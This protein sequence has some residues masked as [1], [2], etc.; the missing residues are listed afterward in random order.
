MKINRKI[1][2]RLSV[3]VAGVAVMSSCSADKDSAGL[4]YMP[5][6]YRSAAIE[7]YVDYGEIR[8]VT[9]DD[10]KV[11]LS[12]MVPPSGTIPFYGTDSMTVALNLPYHRLA[13][14]SFKLS[15]GMYDAELTDVNEYEAAAADGNM[16]KL[17]EENVEGIFAKG[18]ELYNV[19][20]AHCHGDKGDG[21]GP[22]V[23]S[24]AYVGAAVLTSLEI[25]DGQMF[26]SI[27]YGKG[28]M[29][30]H[31]S[32]L[33]KEEIWTVI[34]YINKLKDGSYGPGSE[35]MTEEV[36]ETSEENQPTE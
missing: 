11:R 32:I 19:N 26:Y 10:L 20:C 6:M 15:H 18:K 3:V 33:N 31:S 14:T 24:G 23:E 7:P 27:Y 5:D 21:N 1:I 8:E 25:S 17:T 34:H 12:A 28:Q 9:H 13:N 22:M 29:G 16:I 30:A 2:V 35:M 36:E 4:E